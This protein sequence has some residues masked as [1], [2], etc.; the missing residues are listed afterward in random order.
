MATISSL[1]SGSGLD[2]NGL[3]TNLMQAEQQ[4]MIALQK[5]EAS[6]QTR[7]SA[8]GSLQGTLSALQTAASAMVPA[9]GTTAEAKFI[10]TSYSASI[11]DTSIA[12]A[13]A[14]AGA[15]AGSYSLEVSALA[16]PH[17]LISQQSSQYTASTS[18]LEA[19]GTLRL[20][21]GSMSGGTFAETGYKDIDMTAS[22]KTLGD[23]RDAINAAGAG[24][25]ATIITTTNAGV[26]RAQLVL[27]S[28]S[29]GQDNVMKLS[30]LTGFNFDP[31]APA[32]GT[33]KMSQETADGGLAASNAAFKLN[34]ITGASSG[35]SISGV[36]DGVTLNLSKTTT[37]ATTIT[38]TKSTSNSLATSLNAFVKAYNDANKSMADLGAYNAATKTAGPLQGNSAL[39]SARDQVRGLVFGATAGGNTP[40]QKLSNIGVALG[41][42]GSLSL[43][44]T[45]L[46]AAVAADPTSV[47]NLVAAAGSAF[48]TAVDGLVGT[49]GSITSATDGAKQ[50]VKDLTKRQQVLSNRLSAIQANY[51]KQ[52]TA[53]D[54]LVAGM[55]QTS[56]YLTQQL[57]SLPGVTSSRN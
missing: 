13:T 55:K 35:N 33:G 43:D 24:V 9:T 23:L 21:I 45:K 37:A 34:G 18:T 39:R 25:S 3:L 6:Y 52:F 53:L 40:Y 29:T 32:V 47:A 51:T 50:S 42:D 27:T 14:T 49:S 4:P 28:N 38:V 22:G 8:F 57:A 46:N 30:G 56:T 26:S 15:V 2:L 20:S 17:R 10:T 1:G 16:Q 44:S 48:K 5:Q 19:G 41:K 36:L 54:S 11:A 7:I 31:D 12:T